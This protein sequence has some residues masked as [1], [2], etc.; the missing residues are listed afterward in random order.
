MVPR[1][2]LLFVR[3]GKRLIPLKTREILWI[4]GAGNYARIHTE[5]GCYLVRATLTSLLEKLDE[6]EFLRI[7]KSTLVNVSAITELRS[8]FSGEMMVSLKNGVELKMS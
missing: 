7:H 2:D 4:G 6:I 8:W 1:K 5:Q 3:S